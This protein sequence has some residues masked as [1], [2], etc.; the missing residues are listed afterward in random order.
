MDYSTTRS[1]RWASYESVVRNVLEDPE[2]APWL[3]GPLDQDWAKTLLQQKQWSNHDWR[4]AKDLSWRYRSKRT[5][6]HMAGTLLWISHITS[7]LGFV[8]ISNA[9]GPEGAPFLKL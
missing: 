2:T 7:A 6:D 9:S 1:N 3:D 8:L 5:L 4:S